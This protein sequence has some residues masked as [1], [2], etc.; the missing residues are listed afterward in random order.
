MSNMIHRHDGARECVR[1]A[2]LGAHV[3][4]HPFQA[5]ALHMRDPEA[6]ERH[7]RLGLYVIDLH[8]LGRGTA[9]VA[10]S[11]ELPCD[12]DELASDAQRRVA[13]AIR[14]RDGRSISATSERE[15]R[16]GTIG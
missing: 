15:W 11:Y 10:G 13:D 14:Q 4:I 1:Y 6:I 8:Q 3:S 5:N 16:E 7:A 12:A 2:V 9:T